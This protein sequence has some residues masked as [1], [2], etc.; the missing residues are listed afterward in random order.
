MRSTPS[1]GRLTMR[2]TQPQRARAAAVEVERGAGAEFDEQCGEFRQRRARHALAPAVR[3]HQQQA[4]PV[5][6]QSYGGTRVRR[7]RE[8]RAARQGRDRRAVLH[9]HR[10]AGDRAGHPAL[11]FAQRFGAREDAHA[12]RADADHLLAP[13]PLVGL[14]PDHAVA[15]READRVQRGVE[16]VTVDR[17]QGAAATCEI[18]DRQA[19][20]GRCG[21]DHGKI[22]ALQVHAHGV[23]VGAVAQQV[24]VLDTGRD[25]RPLRGRCDGGSGQPRQ[26]GEEAQCGHRRALSFRSRDCRG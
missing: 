24:Q 23:Q 25:S 5:L 8:V 22:P 16:V 26:Q 2:S 15:H 18:A 17:D 10:P 14:R 21:G 9:D 13:H 1:L 4:A 20:L 3:H 12:P 6:R 11:R 7:E 19:A